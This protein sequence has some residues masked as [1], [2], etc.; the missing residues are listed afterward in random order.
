MLVQELVMRHNFLSSRECADLQGFKFHWAAEKTAKAIAKALDK[1]QKA[2][3]INLTK[4]SEYDAKRRALQ[5]DHCTYVDGK[6]SI[7]NGAYQ[8]L[9]DN[10]EYDKA[11]AELDKEY[12]DLL[13]ANAAFM[14]SDLKVKVHKVAFDDVPK[15]LNRGQTEMLKFMINDEV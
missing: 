15:L 11:S 9:D 2:A 1:G 8:G 6:P 14:A 3:G 13:Q 4:A 12:D 7:V 10:E 5:L